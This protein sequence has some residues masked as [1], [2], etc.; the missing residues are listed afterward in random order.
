MNNQSNVP[1]PQASNRIV[2]NPEKSNLA[3]AQDKEIK[4]A[5]INMA[6]DLHGKGGG[7]NGRNW[8][9]G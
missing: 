5:I 9:D 8:G 1:P 2:L 3:E 6:Q 7:K 4:T